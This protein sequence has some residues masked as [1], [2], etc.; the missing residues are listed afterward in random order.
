MFKKVKAGDLQGWMREDVLHL[1][2]STFFEDPVSYCRE[3]GAESIKESRWR[4][5][6]ILTLP[7]GKRIFLKRDRTKDWFE[8]TKYLFLPTRARK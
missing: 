1:L 4:W 8:S 5:A 6:A 2:S 3:R 7:Y